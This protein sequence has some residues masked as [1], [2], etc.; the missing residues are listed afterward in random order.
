MGYAGSS[1]WTDKKA[2]LFDMDGTLMDSMWMWT[3]ID[4]QYLARFPQTRGTDIRQLQAEIEGMGM[5]ET[6]VYFKKNFQIEDSLEKIQA[7]WDQMAMERYQTRVPLKNGAGDLLSQMRERGLK[8]GICTSNSSALAM[9]AL[10]AN[11]VR[12]L[13]DLVLTADQVGKGKPN[14]DIYLEAAKRVGVKPEDCIVFEDV[15]NGVIAGKR[16]GMQVCGVADENYADKRK[17]IVE[18]ADYFIED[19]RCLLM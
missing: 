11:Q 8:L 13:F 2:A 14:P 7:D 17:D 3:D 6:A 16:A 12:N 5:W 4:I 1:I 9:E 15:L 19:F 10:K 18:A